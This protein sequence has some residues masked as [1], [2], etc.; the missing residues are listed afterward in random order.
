MGRPGGLILLGS[1]A[2]IALIVTTAADD[3]DLDRGS[4]L[5]AAPTSAAALQDE[6]SLLAG[7]IDLDLSGIDDVENLDGRRVS[8]DAEAGEIRV[9]LPPG[10]DVVVDAEI[11]VG[12]D[13]DVAGVGDE[14]RNPQVRYTVVDG[15][16]DVPTLRLDADLTV[17]TIT[18][19]QAQ[20]AFAS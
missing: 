11:G 2:A 5:S 20:E 13:I 14:G 4:E 3:Y 18:V 19:N 6:Y 10:V 9:L 1:L 17:G 15:D 8:V 16:A 12:G 7:R